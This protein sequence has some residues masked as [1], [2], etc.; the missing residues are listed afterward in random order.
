[1][2]LKNDEIKHILS[3]REQGHSYRKIADKTDHSPTTVQ[4]YCNNPPQGVGGQKQQTKTQTETEESQEPQKKKEEKNV[5]YDKIFEVYDNNGSPTEVVKKGLA[6]PETAKKSFEEYTKLKGLNFNTIEQLE[7]RI[8]DLY[9]R[10]VDHYVV[11][12]HYPPDKEQHPRPIKC[13]NCGEFVSP[14]FDP[15]HGRVCE[16]CGETLWI[17]KSKKHQIVGNK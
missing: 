17:D 3:L 14:L 4:K 2:T 6:D 16:E 12:D 8:K 13:Q 10:V 5:P 7:S 1:M 11:E 15:E 9:Q